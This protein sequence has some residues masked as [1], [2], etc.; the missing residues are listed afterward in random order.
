MVLNIFKY[1]NVTFDHKYLV[2]TNSLH[3]I[4]KVL[5]YHNPPNMLVSI[6]DISATPLIFPAIIQSK[7]KIFFILEGKNTADLQIFDLNKKIGPTYLIRTF[8]GHLP[9][10]YS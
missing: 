8:Y 10:R 3:D 4:S 9:E 1:L 5:T 7:N 6:P 2:D